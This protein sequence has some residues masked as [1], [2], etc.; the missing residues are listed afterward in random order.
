MINLN[1][2]YNPDT[3]ILWGILRAPK[4]IIGKWF[5]GV[6]AILPL[7]MVFR[8]SGVRSS[9]GYWYQVFHYHFLHSAYSLALGIVELGSIAAV[10]SPETA[11]AYPP[12]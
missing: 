11:L 6:I 3:F 8:R 2:S 1:Y 12:G 9:L 5:Q 10:S 4:T 7:R